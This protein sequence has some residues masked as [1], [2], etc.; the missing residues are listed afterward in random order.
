M[1]RQ[2][3]PAITAADLQQWKL[4][5]PFQQVLQQVSTTQGLPRTWEDPHRLLELSEYLGL[6]LFGLLN[7]VVQ[8]M[9]GLCAAS[10]LPRVQQQVCQRPVSLGSFSEA[11][12]VVEPQLLQAVFEQLRAQVPSQAGDPR[13]GQRP[14][15]LVDSTLWAALPRMHWALWRTQGPRQ[16]AVRWHIGFHLLTETPLHATLTA[17][18]RCERAVWRE[19]WQAGAA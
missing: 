6:F 17:G 4:L 7:P 19:H 11:Q 1:A 16:Q 14:W 5:A 8:T 9:R 18:R 3:Q 10:T 2:S 12:H 13:L 15:Q